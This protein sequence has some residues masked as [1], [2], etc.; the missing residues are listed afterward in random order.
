MRIG[1]DLT[2]LIEKPTGVDRY[3]IGLAS[4]LAKYA[5]SDEYVLFINAEDRVRVEKAVNGAAGVRVVALSRRPRALRIFSQQAL[6]PVAVRRMR[7]D[8]VHSP[9]FI[10]PFW[11]G[12]G[13]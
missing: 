4:S 7:I 12:R 6:L 2:A 10:M 11:R 13:G 9:A 3:L 1:I 5:S 8:V